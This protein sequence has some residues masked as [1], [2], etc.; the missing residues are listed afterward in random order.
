MENCNLTDLNKEPL[1]QNNDLIIFIHNSGEETIYECFSVKELVELLNEMSIR[2]DDGKDNLDYFVLPYSEI[3]INYEQL[4]KYLIWQKF[5][6]FEVLSNT[7]DDIF[8]IAPVSR[9]K[10]T[11]TPYALSQWSYPT[12]TEL[13]PEEFKEM[14]EIRAMLDGIK[15]G[16]KY[17]LDETMTRYDYPVGEGVAM[18]L[19]KIPS[20]LRPIHPTK[21]ATSIRK[22]H[23]HRSHDDPI[24]ETVLL[25]PKASPFIP[26]K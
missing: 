8:N 14:N 26:S 16:T 23:H 24:E 5:N 11:N 3:R 12:A 2:Y 18:E 22:R 10:V 4:V 7:T 21:L 19:H 15:Y 17:V 9:K 6:T 20:I 13:S 25:N 1:E